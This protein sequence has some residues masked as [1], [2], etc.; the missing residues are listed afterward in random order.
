[1]VEVAQGDLF[2]SLGGRLAGAIDVI[3]CNPPYL[4]TA[5]LAG[6]GDLASEPREAFDGGTYGFAI[7]QRVARDALALLRIG[8]WLVM[9]IGLGQYRQV[10]QLVK[11][12]R[13][14]D[15]IELHDD[16]AG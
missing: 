8:G 13:G 6:R 7:H 12:A 15:P 16:E 3:A 5:T 10:V 14:Y 9:E 11:R 1:R 4:S 2:A